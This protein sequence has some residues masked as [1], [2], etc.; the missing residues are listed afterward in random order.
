[1]QARVQALEFLRK[2]QVSNVEMIAA[3]LENRS[4]IIYQSPKCVLLLETTSHCYHL[5]CEN[6]EDLQ[7]LDT[8]LNH[9][10]GNFIVHD[11]YYLDYLKEKYELNVHETCYS[12]VYEK[13][14][15]QMGETYDIRRLDLSYLDLVLEK[16][17]GSNN[18]D[19]LSQVI[20]VYGLYGIFVENKIAGFIGTHDDCAMG[21]LEIFDEY[22]GKGYATLLES[23]LINLRLKENKIAFC[24]V[25]D[26]NEAS[27]ALQRK[28]GMSIATQP[29]HW[30]GK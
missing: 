25:I 26:G 12:C 28:L 23:Y 3:I 18:P 14:E 20:E 9:C 1:M 4:R 22:Q 29:L 6:L 10:E 7:N 15:I 21:L 11:S 24:Q 13:S 16:Y 17:R 30:L 2:D 5:K 8:F 27:F 19:Y